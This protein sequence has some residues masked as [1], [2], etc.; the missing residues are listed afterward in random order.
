M[1]KIIAVSL[2][3]ATVALM[4]ISCASG[5]KKNV[6]VTVIDEISVSED[7]NNKVDISGDVQVPEEADAAECIRSLCN[8]NGIVVEGVD[9]GFITKVADVENA[10][11]YAWMF[12][13]N[14]ELSEDK[15]ISD[16]IPEQG[17]KIELRY[18]DFTEI[19]AAYE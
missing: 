6:T 15:G 19:F 13:I 3:L 1:K 10:G 7:G 14:G 12:Y 11:N 5:N 9:N 16:Y 17:D 8:T 18:V 2:V 4:L